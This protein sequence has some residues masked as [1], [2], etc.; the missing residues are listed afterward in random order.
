MLRKALEQCGCEGLITTIPK[1]GFIFEADVILVAEK[2]KDD[3]STHGVIIEKKPINPTSIIEQRE[4]KPGPGCTSFSKK[5]A[6]VVLA[7]FFTMVFFAPEIY[8]Y[9]KLQTDRN[10][11]LNIKNCSVYTTD[12]KI[13]SN[14]SNESLDVIKSTVVSFAL[15]CDKKANI[16]YFSE[17]QT[18][19]LG[20]EFFIRT[21]SYCPYKSKVPCENYYF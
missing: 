13:V 12:N 9:L 16:Y 4:V 2:G 7:A 11:V 15:N 10:K 14:N 6:G 5:V 18:N 8:S 19:S 21:L 17:S 3:N 20:H 1:Y